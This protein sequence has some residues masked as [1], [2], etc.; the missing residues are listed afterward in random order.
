MALTPEIIKQQEPLKG[1]TDE[2]ISSLVTLSTNDENDVIGKRIGEIYGALDADIKET[3]GVE[4][5][6]GEKTYDFL[7]RV[8]RTI[9]D[10]VKK[11]ADVERRIVQ[12]EGEKTELEDKIKSGK[13]NEAIN[14]KLK[15]TSDKLD[16]LKQKYDNDRK[17]WETK[18]SEKEQ[19]IKDVHVTN[20][21]DKA[22]IGMTFKPEIS[23][24]LQAVMLNSARSS[25][26][27]KFSPDFVDDGNGST[28]MVFRNKEGQ[29]ANNPDNGLN[30]YTADELLAKELKPALDTT[31]KKGTGTRKPDGS[32]H[33]DII[34][35][36]EAK[37]QIE[38]DRIIVDNLLAKGLVKG[39]DK[40]DTEQK[41]LRSEHKV[42]ELPLR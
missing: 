5:N 41:R 23:E 28:R 25:I 30:P 3:F 35:I 12:L 42:A 27:G 4:K 11:Y 6:Q 10:K 7:K 1:L 36:S 16:E 37:T 24:D 14:Q 31:K 2:Q 9:T 26:L 19:A 8:G 38:A 40:F 13:G 22:R 34:P 39:S 32:R 15:D 17:E 29:I 33:D 21:F 20:A 18:L